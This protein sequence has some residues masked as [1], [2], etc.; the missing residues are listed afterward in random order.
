VIRYS[1]FVVRRSLFLIATK[2]PSHQGCFLCL[3]VFVAIIFDLRAII[4]YS[5]FFTYKLGANAVKK[6]HAFFCESALIIADNYKI[7]FA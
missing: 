7:L 5:I 2:A 6:N 3:C 1:L 4:H